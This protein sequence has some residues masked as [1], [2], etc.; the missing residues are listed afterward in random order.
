[1]PILEYTRYKNNWNVDAY[2]MEF[3]YGKED[4]AYETISLSRN[5]FVYKWDVISI[6]GVDVNVLMNVS[7]KSFPIYT[8]K[9]N[10]YDWRE[11]PI[12]ENTLKYLD[13]NISRLKIEFNN[14]V[15]KINNFMRFIE[16][17]SLYRDIVEYIR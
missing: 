14:D 4:K 9:W 16:V 10:K 1:M 15:D 8:Y 7:D 13:K 5:K 3:E 2:I 11:D 12:Y 6:C 17:Q